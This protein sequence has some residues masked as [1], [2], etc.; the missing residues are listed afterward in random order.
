MSQNLLTGC[1]FVDVSR[2]SSFRTATKR[3]R[4]LY[5]C[6]TIPGIA[7]ARYLALAAAMLCLQTYASPLYAASLS[8]AWSGGGYISPSKG[9]RER[10]SCRVSYSR[11]SS[12]VYSVAAV[13]ATT[14]AKIRQSGEVLMVRPNLYVGDFYNRQ[15]DISGRIRVVIRGSRQTVT[16]SSSSGGGRLSLRKR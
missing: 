13:C 7:F 16:M 15:L 10:V 9:K 6:I 2:N 14:S 8:G 3:C 12:K 1:R 5:R 11:Q 4:Q